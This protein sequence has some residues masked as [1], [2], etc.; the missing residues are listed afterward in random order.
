MKK[1]QPMK[2]IGIF[3]V[4]AVIS[5]LSTIGIMF[6]NNINF[7][8]ILAVST[9][10]TFIFGGLSIGLLIVYISYNFRIRK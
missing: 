10:L 9:M 7:G 6:T 1:L 2:L 4:I 5:G 3:A 8:A